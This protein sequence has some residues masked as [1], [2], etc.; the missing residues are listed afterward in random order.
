MRPKLGHFV[1]LLLAILTAVSPQSPRASLT[2]NCSPQS[3]PGKCVLR[4]IKVLEKDIID[5]ATRPTT[6]KTVV[7]ENSQLEYLPEVLFKRFPQLESLQASGVGLKRF[8]PDAFS[9]SPNLKNLDVS[10]NSVGILP[11]DV[12]G[13]CQNLEAIDI[14]HNR[15]HLFN[16][17][18]LIGCNKL[19][20]LN[21]SSNQLIFFNWEP[22]NDLRLLEQIDLS[23]N[24]ISNVMIPRYAKKVVARNNHI[25]KLTTD[26]NSFIFMLEH[27]DAS[28]NRL[29]NIDT[30]ARF[31]KMT[32][33]DLSYN[34]LLTV[35]FALFKNMPSLRELKLD[36]NN[37]FSVSTSDVKPIPL[38]LVDLS[39]NELTRLSAND[40]RGISQV[41]RLRL[42]NNYLVKFEVTKGL[43][44]F[45]RLKSV[46]LSGNDWAC[47]DMEAMLMEF[48][49]RKVM[50]QS[51]D[52]SC[53]THLIKKKGL[54]CRDLGTSFD[55]L[56]LLETQKLSEIQQR[57]T[58]RMVVTSTVRP[59]MAG[60]KQASSTMTVP[61][62]PQT[63]Q[64]PGET[65]R[66][67]ESL[68]ETMSRLV[69]V[70]TD[71]KNSNT[72]K[73]R[74]KTSL[75]GALAEVKTLNEKLARCKSTVNQRTGQTVLID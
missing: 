64:Y 23:N 53:A 37:I 32:Y 1:S 14:A 70:E 31:G 39:N 50:L 41:E 7:F 3:K 62:K 43:S 16:G 61:S 35:D 51:V 24:L 42:N 47:P 75:D 18:E 55:E 34:R 33:I 28:R 48:S 17:I 68:R 45:P 29:S 30:M 56:V 69:V 40:I 13:T 25:H 19:R 9:K 44:N 27:L 36:R 60:Q 10:S 72:E 63:N 67:S 6:D 2:L 4:S 66:L 46:T 52:E 49:S 5:N 11:Q 74:L 22:L 15:L 8:S 65:Q 54:C 26:P 38:E 57:P 71:L 20:Q 21:V 58:G 12:F 73:S 59:V